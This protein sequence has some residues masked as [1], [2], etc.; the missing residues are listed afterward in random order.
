MIPPSPDF[1]EALDAARL[2]PPEEVKALIDLPSA[3][4]PHEKRAATVF[5]PVKNDGFMAR[6]PE[7]WCFMAISP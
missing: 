6:H 1:A 5:S 4:A 2:H 3:S 7:K